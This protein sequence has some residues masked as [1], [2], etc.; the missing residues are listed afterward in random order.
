MTYQLI[1]VTNSAHGYMKTTQTLQQNLVK[2]GANSQ[3]F[4]KTTRTGNAIYNYTE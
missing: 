2:M 3:R 4:A 1:H